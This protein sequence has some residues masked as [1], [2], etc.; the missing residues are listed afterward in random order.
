M[1]KLVNC[2]IVAALGFCFAC[3]TG[4]QAFNPD[5]KYAPEALRKDYRLFRSIL[6]ESHP[7]LY[8]YT[9]PDSLQAYFDGGYARITDSMTLPAFRTLLSYT[10][11]KINCGHTSVRYSKA[12][13]R[14]LDT[15]RLRLFP[16]S[17]KL[18]K[19][20][21]VV[22]A[23]INRRDSVLRRGVVIKSING[24]SQTTI[25]D[26]LFNY[27]VT[28]GYSLTGKYQTL[29]SDF[30]FGAWYK[31][32]FGLP[33]QL[34]IHYL[35][36]AGQEKQVSVPVYDPASDTARFRHLSQPRGPGEK[37]V[38]KRPNFEVS[39]VRNLQVD[40]AGSTGFMTVSTFSRGYQLKRFFRRS[41]RTLRENHI[42]DLVID[43]RSNGG[44]EASN[45]TLLTRYLI[46]R[47]FKIADSLY[48]VNRH[49]RHY[50]KY[51]GN[52]L[53]YRTM[54]LF[55]TKK[56][57]DGKYH[58][59]YFER[60][61]FK[62]K[63]KDHFDGQVYVLIGGNSFSAT[64]LFAG[65]LKGQ[66]NVTMVGEETGGGSYGNSAWM[67]PE[68]TLPNTGLRFRLPKFHLVVN[69][70]WVKDGHGVMPDVPALPT[71]TA[72]KQGI[73]FKA[74]KARELILSHSAQKP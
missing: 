62:P 48:A 19:D 74:E 36:S 13:N 29:S 8:W 31:N 37:K 27:L 73:D 57:R 12:F 61:Y 22:T 56:H 70:N 47:K 55:V 65:S 39:L 6:E 40:T 32:V 46:D 69:R 1:K 33:D 11:S 66:K 42:R 28:D 15:A 54:M 9:S 58:F 10:I 72:I 24:L 7:S 52:S 68:V 2:L 45:S 44:G 67:I 41:F 43:V 3:Q 23:N 4:K 64:T 60:H 5:K 17:V 38:P 35:D 63:N 71:T 49:S 50:D 26:S 14:Y 59:G 18:W 53:L 30:G 20:T 25:R 51:I 21:M 16:L 34:D